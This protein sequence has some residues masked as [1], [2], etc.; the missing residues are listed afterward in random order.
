MNYRRQ[1]KA[2]TL[3]EILLVVGILVVL[4]GV[5]VG[6][7]VNVRPGT[8]EKL[9]Q[10]KVDS[11]ADAV[12]VYA[13]QMG[14][15]PDEEDGLDALITAPDDE[16]KAE[17]WQKGGGPF[18]K[19]GQIPEDPWGFELKYKRMEEGPVKFI[20]YSV[21]PDGDPET[22]DDIKSSDIEDEM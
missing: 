14:E 7:Y 18:L 12:E 19:D 2:F 17:Q 5:V 10:T 13:L 22:D 9:A 3:I 15:Y 11:T 16:E 21:G 8:M 4:A 6:V 20:V 1:R